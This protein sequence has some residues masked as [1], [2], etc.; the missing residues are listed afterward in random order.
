MLNSI[1]DRQETF[2]SINLE[3]F[4][5]LEHCK[6]VEKSIS[7]YYFLTDNYSNL[8]RLGSLFVKILMCIDYRFQNV[9]KN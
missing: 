7:N 5:I 2:D 8:V 6:I 3:L 4:L 9:F 1:C